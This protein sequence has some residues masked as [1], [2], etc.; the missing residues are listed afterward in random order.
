M[1]L[2][3]PIENASNPG[4]ALTF[5]EQYITT[6]PARPKKIVLVSPGVSETSNLVNS[7]RARLEPRNAT[8]DYIQV[9]PGQRLTNLPSSGRP[10]RAAGTTTVVTRTPPAAVSDTTAAIPG[11]ENRIFETA[12]E[13]R[14]TDAAGQQTEEFN[15]NNEPV[16]SQESD[17]SHTVP[18]PDRLTESRR[19]WLNE[20][21]SSSLPYILGLLLLLLLLGLL[22]FFFSQKSRSRS[23][24][25][26]AAAKPVS[27]VPEPKE[28]F[29]DHSKD[30]AKYASVQSRRTTPYDD[31]PAADK[32]IVIN[33]SGP[34]LL[35]LFV[36]DQNT[37]IG[38]RN[39]HSL[40][41]GYSLSIGGGKSDDYLIF[42]VDIPPQIGEI[43][44]NGSQLSFIPRKP[45]YFPDIGSNEIKDCLNKTIRIIS[46][47]KY[48]VRFRLEMYED[49]LVTLNRLLMSVKVPG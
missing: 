24:S 6:L 20:T 45:K 32:N 2:Q 11:E 25:S 46:D 47:K 31:R 23:S 15:I 3:Y 41:S 4:S 33:P 36:E 19:G 9:I 22:I 29:V 48:E 28:K 12:E 7:T 14:Y 17:I 39:I 37:A 21:W 16:L 10:S 38:K 18:A 40:K 42:L 43:R 30:L 34:L 44:R 35:N 13:T 27:T 8:L 49:P 1:L 5:A 26:R